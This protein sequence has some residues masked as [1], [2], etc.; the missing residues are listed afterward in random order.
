C[1][2]CISQSVD[3]VPQCLDQDSVWAM[4]AAHN[5]DL[6]HESTVDRGPLL[7]TRLRLRPPEM[8]AGRSLE[9]LCGWEFP[10]STEFAPVL[11]AF[12]WHAP[13]LINPGHLRWYGMEHSLRADRAACKRV[14]Q[15]PGI[16]TASYQLHGG[17]DADEYANRGLL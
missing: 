2:S 15:V 14:E 8:S 11:L 4:P 7:S 5:C 16:A 12:A 17:H 9:Q 6:V 13:W 10:V 3:R 1:R